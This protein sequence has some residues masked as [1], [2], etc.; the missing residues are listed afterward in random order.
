[1]RIA[2]VGNFRAEFSTENDIR[3]SLE[4]MGH[5]VIKLQEDR[6]DP[7]VIRYTA[8]DL[9]C[10]ALFWTMTWPH[11]NEVGY[12][13]DTVDM[14]KA[15]GIPSIAYHLDLFWGISRGERNPANEP[16]FAM[17]HVFTPDN[18]HNESWER[19]GV[20]HHYL[21]PGVLEES[22]YVGRKRA[23]YSGVDVAFVGSRGYHPEWP[24]RPDLIEELESRFRG[25]FKLMGATEA[26][27]IRGR[28]LNDF[29][30]SVP[31]IVGD[32]LCLDH[33]RSSYWSDRVYETT[34][35]HGLLAMPAIDQLAEQF[36]G[37]M[38]MWSWG[39]FDEME[40]LVRMMLNDPHHSQWM[41]EKC[42][43]I[44]R[45]NHTYRHRLNKVFRTVFG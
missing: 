39:D 20:N 19:I 12:T 41:R 10:D 31:V 3:K 21:P 30:A 18:N 28:M 9:G 44:T 15:K 33:E 22:C 17:E 29:Y 34:G 38:P 11:F 24:H 42:A 27:K 7:E 5:S 13:M 45:E 43:A 32:S 1:M 6:T 4:S 26:T 8:M 40:H 35:R 37:N 2:Y 16:M 25:S 14:L 23:S 36:D